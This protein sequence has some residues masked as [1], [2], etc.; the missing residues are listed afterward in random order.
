MPIEINEMGVIVGG[1]LEEKDYALAVMYRA[2]F[3]AE[4]WLME[5][6]QFRCRGA[7]RLEVIVRGARSMVIY[8]GMGR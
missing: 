8:C 5:S 6:P 2:L 7:A 3:D 1:T 4:M